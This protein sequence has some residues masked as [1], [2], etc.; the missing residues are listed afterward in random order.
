[1]ILRNWQTV[2]DYDAEEWLCEHY[3][4][5]ED[6]AI[7]EHGFSTRQEAESWALTENAKEKTFNHR[8]PFHSERQAEADAAFYEGQY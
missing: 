1:M 5:G 7:Y 2:Y 8:D 4:G 3:V 6:Y